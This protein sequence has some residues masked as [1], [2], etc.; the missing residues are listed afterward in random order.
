MLGIWLLGLLG[1]LN[2]ILKTIMIRQW[3]LNPGSTMVLH[4]RPPGLLQNPA[5]LLGVPTDHINIRS[6]QN[7]NHGIPLILGHG[8]RMSGPYVYVP[9]NLM[10]R[11][12]EPGSISPAHGSVVPTEPANSGSRGDQIKVTQSKAC[13]YICAVYIHIYIYIHASSLNSCGVQTMSSGGRSLRSVLN[14]G[15]QT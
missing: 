15:P 4:V 11:A 10:V 6:P 9:S 14:R 8:T 2:E 7:M 1:S 13:T 3:L 5:R 12:Q